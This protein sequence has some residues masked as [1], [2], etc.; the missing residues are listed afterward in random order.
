MWTG[1]HGVFYSKNNFTAEANFLINVE[2]AA[3]LRLIDNLQAV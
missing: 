2:T 1:K 3:T